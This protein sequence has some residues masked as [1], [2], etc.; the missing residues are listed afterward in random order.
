ME[1]LIQISKALQDGN[2]ETV[3][4]LTKEAISQ[5]IPPKQILDDGL[6]HGINIIGDQFRKHEIFLPDVLLAAKA[7]YAG[8]DQ[9]KPLLIRDKIPGMGKI[10]LGTVKGDVHDI[11]KNLVGIMLKGAGFEVIDLGKDV[12]AEKFVERAIEEEADV[13]GMSTL[14]TTTMQTMQ[15]VTQLLKAKNPGRSI[16]TIV[17]GAPLSPEIAKEFG[18]DA[19]AYDAGNAVERVKLLI[20]QQ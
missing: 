1:L 18:A 8:M 14:L 2:D 5:N 10:V 19:Y 12:P 16:K 20:G 6:L 11:G 7:M 13:I 15:E 17:G 4:E 3:F 9:L